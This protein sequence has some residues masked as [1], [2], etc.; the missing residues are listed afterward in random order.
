LKGMLPKLKSSKYIL[1]YRSSLGTF[2]YTLVLCS[3]LQHPLPLI[4][5]NIYSTSLM[6]NISWAS[7]MSCCGIRSSAVKCNTLIKLAYKISLLLKTSREQKLV[8]N[9]MRNDSNKTHRGGERPQRGGGLRRG[10]GGLRRG[11]T[12]LGLGRSTGAAVISC[13][14]ICPEI[15]RNMTLRRKLVSIKVSDHVHRLSYSSLWNQYNKSSNWVLQRPI[16]DRTFI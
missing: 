7:L 10:M 9:I 14:S 2:W 3:I 12:G 5:M 6:H 1:V 13:P 11:G 15:A 16:E 8:S 4:K